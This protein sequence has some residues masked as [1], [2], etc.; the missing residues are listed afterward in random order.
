MKVS[1]KQG[2]LWALGTA[3]ISGVSVYVN[4][5]GVAQFQDPFVYTTLKNSLVAIGFLAALG[6]F[7]SWR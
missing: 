7:A 3:L 1:D 5:F 6:L 4:K 2:I